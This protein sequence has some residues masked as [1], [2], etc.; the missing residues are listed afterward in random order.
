ML[1]RDPASQSPVL[2]PDQPWVHPAD[3]AAVQR[4]WMRHVDGELPRYESEHRRQA[5]DGSW[6]WVLERGKVVERDQQGRVQRA[7]GVVSDVSERRALEASLSSAERLESL[8]LVAGGLARQFDELLGVIRAHASLA[9]VEANLPPRVGESLEVIQMAVARAKSL[10][11]SVQALSPQPVLAPSELVSVGS[12]VRD[13][14]PLFQA[15]LLRT[16]TLTLQDR[17]QG[18]DLVRADPALLQQCAMN[19][20]LRAAEAMA[21]SGPLLLRVEPAGP[22]SVA[23]R[24]IDAAPPMS[25]EAA[26]RI[27]EALDADGTLLGRTALGMATVRRFADVTG[28]TLYASPSPPGNAVTLELP[29]QPGE[30]VVQ[31]PV[32]ALCE[33]HPLLGPMLAEALHAAGHRVLRA[34]RPERLVPLLQAE[35]AGSVAVVDE[36]GWRAVAPVWHATCHEAGCRPGVVVLADT[37]A[38]PLGPGFE[39]LAKPF[40]AEALLAAVGRVSAWSASLGDAS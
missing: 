32:V 28:G 35:R 40:A 16:V 30:V 9:H 36:R 25:P 17:C 18:N 34:D 2:P 20:V 24:C 27:G 8:G 3:R 26:L 6:R 23:L 33:D 15:A 7:V 14:L 12:V 22:A 4:A 29:L 5:A 37:V 19:M 38:G 1:G 13:A 21:S 11:R 10:V 39:W 31:R